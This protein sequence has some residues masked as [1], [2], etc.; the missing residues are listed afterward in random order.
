MMR[1]KSTSIIILMI[2]LFILWNFT[3]YIWLGRNQQGSIQISPDLSGRLNRLQAKLQDQM[4]T[5]QKLLTE[6]DKQKELILKNQKLAEEAERRKLQEESK[7]GVLTPP[8]Q[9]AP[10]KPEEGDVKLPEDLPQN[11]EP[12]AV[13][14]V[15]VIACNRPSAIKRS[16]DT[17]LQNRLSQEQFPIIV[18]QDCGHAETASVIESF[19]DKITFIKQPDLGKITDIP[20]NMKKFE[21]YYKISRHYKWAL[22]QAFNR[23]NYNSVIIVEDDLDV[24]VDFFH[25]FAA[26]HHLLEEDDTVWCVSAWNDNGKAD[27]VKDPEMLY[28]SDF[29][30]G[31]G[32]MLTKKVW[33]ELEPKWPAGFWDD[34]M[35][36][37]DQRKDRAC[38]RPEISRTDTFG[39]EGV[40]KGQYFEQHLKY[41]VMNKQ[42]VD[43]TKK[44]LSY[45]K[46]DNYDKWFIGEVYSSPE[47]TLSKLREGHA[48]NQEKVRV[49]YTS[50]QSFKSYANALSIMNDFKA[51]VPRTAYLGVVTFMY[52][53]VRVYV[54]P[55]KNWK[56]YDV[57]W[58]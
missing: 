18:S 27:K 20:A 39:K 43:F 46:K 37:P 55:P 47:I 17:L 53:N 10:D 44:D 42:F 22:S 45:L 52:S 51:G 49:T 35:R 14:A 54:A 11:Q 16:L 3:I 23:F 56:G 21:G 12:K 41:I 4:E 33:Q 24:A 32:W 50:Q 31:L 15:L 26:T 38:I 5:N 2:L 40:S 25:Y 8:N 7:Q 9:R 29:F 13:I 1:L 6:I 58:S 19:G 48:E 36:H 34:W 28:R 57:T 30:P